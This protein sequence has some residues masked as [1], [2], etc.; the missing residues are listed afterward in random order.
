MSTETRR[1]NVMTKF[2]Y[3]D[4]LIACIA[5]VRFLVIGAVRELVI[6]NGQIVVK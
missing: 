4:N 2:I 3:V 5:Q 1:N 6:L